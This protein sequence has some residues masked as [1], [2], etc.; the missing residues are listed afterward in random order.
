M[1]E[2]KTK[3]TKIR[4]VDINSNRRL[5][6]S[7]MFAL[8]QE[9][10]WEYH[11][12]CGFGRSETVDKG[13]LWMVGSQQA[14]ISR[15]PEYEEEVILK[16]WP[17]KTIMGFF[18]RYSRIETLSGEHLVTASAM[19]CLVDEKT[20]KTVSPDEL[21]I[22]FE[23]II[24]GNEISTTQGPKM[25]PVTD[26]T[27]FQIPYSYTDL[28]GHLNSNRYFDLSDD[29]LPAAASG[30]SPKLIIARYGPETL[31]GEVLSIDTGHDPG[32]ASDN[33]SAGSYYMEC[34]SKG[35]VRFRM[36]IEY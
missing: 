10:V 28:N 31:A 1:A 12:E 22:S 4:T 23:P 24:T 33:S 19:W 20:R 7:A 3:Q 36:R 11:S 14:R 35:T 9:E 2:I 16:T 21:G 29:I 27:K 6:T 25:I 32:T 15:M 8:L 18:P 17:G 30:L 5:R 26:H 13:I 34:S